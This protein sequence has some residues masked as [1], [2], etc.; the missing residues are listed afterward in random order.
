[1]K[2]KQQQQQILLKITYMSS[3]Q[4]NGQRVLET[5]LKNKKGGG[6]NGEK[7]FLA[8]KDVFWKFSS[9][10]LPLTGSC[11]IQRKKKQFLSQSFA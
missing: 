11:Q 7:S 5:S 1:M 3:K 10:W 8:F 4:Q 6:R 9:R 2:H